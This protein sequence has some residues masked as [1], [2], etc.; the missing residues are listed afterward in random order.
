MGKETILTC[1]RV[2]FYA[3]KDEDA[4]FEW[5]E[6]IPSI[7]KFDGRGDELY[8][9]LD[10]TEISDEDLDE[11]LAL[12]YRYKIDMKQLKIFLSEH[13]KEWFF[14]NPIAY[15]HKKVFGLAKKQKKQTR[16]V[17]H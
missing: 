17:T 5:I 1:K 6:K 16:R 7:T 9:Y 10:S 2:T 4:F 15:W 14:D 3:P 8:L 11:I 12:F 13:N